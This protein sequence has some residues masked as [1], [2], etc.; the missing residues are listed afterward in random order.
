M[1]KRADADSAAACPSA[2]CEP[3]SRLHGL[4]GPDGRLMRLSP[5]L[6]IDQSF[7]EAARQGRSPTKRFRFTS[8]CVEGRCGQWR[9]GK[10]GVA[11]KAREQ[12][13]G[14]AGAEAHVRPGGRSSALPACAI[15]STCRWFAQEGGDICAACS[16]VVTDQS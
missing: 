10:C 8:E 16:F 15:R 4:F 13:A 6:E 11:I 12:L 7:V 2:A 1:G 9:D 14:H 3:G 5:P